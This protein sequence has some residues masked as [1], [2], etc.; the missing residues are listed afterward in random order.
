MY[1]R[2]SHFLPVSALAAAA[3]ALAACG[4]SGPPAGSGQPSA[5]QTSGST[6]PGQATSP[7]TSATPVTCAG[8]WLTGSHSVTRGVAVPPV[9]VATA[10]RPGSHPECRFD[11]LVIDINGPVPGYSARYVAQVTGDGSGLPV[12]MPGS[13]YLVITLTPAQGHTDAGAATLT[14]NLKLVNFPMLKG[15]VVSGDFEGYLTVAL[16]LAGG[17]RYRIG[18]L[19]GRLYVDI[20]W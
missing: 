11:R 15:Y 19:P 5:P 12:T 17:T 1:R 3:L 8:G 13:K 14:R 9:P 18:E 4:T 16:G 20:A 2:S 10:L 7:T 6:Q